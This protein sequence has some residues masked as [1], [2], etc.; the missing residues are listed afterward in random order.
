MSEHIAMD[1]LCA[2]KHIHLLVR[3]HTG[4]HRDE[5]FAVVGTDISHMPAA[6]FI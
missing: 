6:P 5:V 3:T 4:A 2:H 1:V